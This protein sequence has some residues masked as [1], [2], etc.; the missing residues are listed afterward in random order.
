VVRPTR[1]GT[2]TNTATVSAD[3]PA[4]PDTTNNSAT[5]TTTVTP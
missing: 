2:F 5:E 3:R 1:K 4:D